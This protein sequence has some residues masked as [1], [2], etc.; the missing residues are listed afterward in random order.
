MRPEQK[1]TLHQIQALVLAALPMS[2][3]ICQALWRQR[4]AVEFTAI[5]GGEAQHR[6]PSQGTASEL[7]L[8]QAVSTLPQH[9]SVW[10]AWSVMGQWSE[11]HSH[12]SFA[13]ESLD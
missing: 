11:T 8:Q 2:C 1:D 10:L 5:P 9:G 12:I 7:V 3:V 6:L 4:C 13:I